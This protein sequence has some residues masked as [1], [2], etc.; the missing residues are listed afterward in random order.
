MAVAS[1]GTDANAQRHDKGDRHGAGGHA[2]GI[3][4]HGQKAF[5]DEQRQGEYHCVK[6]QKQMGQGDAQQHTQHGH[7]QKQPDARRHRIDQRAVGD[8]GHLLRQHLQVRLGDGDDEAQNK[9][10]QDHQPE[11]AAPGD[12]RAG[13]GAHGRHGGL[14]AQREKHN[15]DN[16]HHCA[17]Q[18]AQQNAGGDRCD[19]KAQHQ[20]DANNGQHR[21]HGLC[22][23]FLELAPGNVQSYDRLS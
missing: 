15:A 20:H 8:G 6:A 13:A 10:H 12:L 16:D 11:L 21:L 3:E 22:K 5:W 2:A 23:L 17:H 14:R 1:D 19:G 7:H 9:A 4:G 18:K